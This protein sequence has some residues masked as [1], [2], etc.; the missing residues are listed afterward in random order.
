VIVSA[1]ADFFY[2]SY[3]NETEINKIDDKNAFELPEIIET[4]FGT[5]NDEEVVGIILRYLYHN[6][7]FKKIKD[8]INEENIF[9]TLS[10]SNSLGMPKLSKKLGEIIADNILNETNCVR[11]FY[12]ALM[13]TIIIISA[14]E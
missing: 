1:G 5:R 11:I 9:N 12:E 7:K 6:Q 3:L 14:R 4:V 13:V 8:E 10:V 2:E